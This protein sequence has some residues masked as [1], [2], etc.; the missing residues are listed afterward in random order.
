MLHILQCFCSEDEGDMCHRTEPPKE[1][2]K[3]TTDNPKKTEKVQSAKNI[4]AQKS[5]IKENVVVS[6][7]VVIFSEVNILFLTSLNSV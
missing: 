4:T 7:R 1:N 3:E 5:Q 6:F 2:T